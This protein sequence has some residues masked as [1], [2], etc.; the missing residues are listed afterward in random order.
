MSPVPSRDQKSVYADEQATYVHTS[1]A[2]LFRSGEFSNIRPPRR[3]DRACT[4]WPLSGQNCANFDCCTGVVSSALLDELLVDSH[5]YARASVGGT[6]SCEP[7]IHTL[8]HYWRFIRQDSLLTLCWRILE[9]QPAP[10]REGVIMVPRPN[11]QQTEEP[12]HVTFCCFAAHPVCAQPKGSDG[13]ALRVTAIGS[14]IRPLLRTGRCMQW[15][16]CNYGL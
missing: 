14:Q 16:G 10:C 13:R 3:S 9:Q 4:S 15:L 1:A 8:Q 7:S 2:E 11:V 12:H 5:K 6:H